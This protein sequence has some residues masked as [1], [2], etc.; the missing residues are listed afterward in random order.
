MSD[1]ERSPDIDAY[2]SR[3]R[4]R[5]NVVIA[6]ILL[7][8]AAPFVLLFSARAFELRATPSEAAATFTLQRSCGAVL[9]FGNRALLLSEQGCLDA[10]AQGYATE[11]VRLA[12]GSGQQQIEV[13][14]RPLP[15]KVVIA[16]DSAAEFEV[17]V[18]RN[19]LGGAS[20]IEV[21]LERG[22]HELLVRG[23]RIVPIERTIDVTG[24][25]EEQRFDFATE[26]SNSKFSVRALPDG[27]EILLD[28]VKVGQAAHAD[29]VALGAHEVE[30]RLDGYHSVVRRFTAEPNS[31]ADLGLIEL[32]PKDAI[33]SLSSAPTGASVLVDD[34]FVGVAPLR[35]RLAALRTHGLT[36]RKAGHNAIETRIRP[37]PG[38]AIQR[39]FHLGGHRFEADVSADVEAHLTVNGINRGKTPMSVQVREGDRI[40]VAREGY[41]TQSVTVARVGG[42]R[43][44][45]AFRMMRPN[46]WAFDQAPAVVEAA[47]GST[48]R[49]FPPVRFR[50]WLADES[51]QGGEKTLKRA[52]YVGQ[53]EVDYDGFRSFD[54]IAIPKGLSGKHP[55]ANITWKRAAEFCNWLSRREGLDPVYEFG[56]RGELRRVESSA[57]GYRLPTEA[58]WEAVSGYDFNRNEPVGPYPWGSAVTIPRAYANFA[59]REA[60][61][62]AGRLLVGHADNH[63]STAPTGSYPANFNGL[64]D[65]AG[66]VA[67]WTTDYYAAAPP[68]ADGQS[69]V[70][71]LGPAR[72]V[73][74]VVK[75]SSFKSHA[76]SDLVS[77]HRM[78]ESTK[79]DSVGFRIARWIH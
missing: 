16:V 22:P 76:L 55:V 2:I 63:A 71:P 59:G 60:Q 77:G 70:D 48:L 25:G 52:F 34:K 39:T 33:L 49:K 37:S 30:V 28:G 45:Y 40:S 68:G 57:L 44:T 8:A 74:H 65:L 7:L 24:Y 66:N 61:A 12:K 75:G 20:P 56:A 1:F 32:E 58:E 13:V 67:E 69:L 64:Y 15:G 62:L 72:G 35:I 50:P 23:P 42:P 38:E 3:Q 4:R 26:P 11:T 21:E 79:S 29:E 5:R 43:R 53:R 51:G 6:A 54:P 18:D 73:D 19:V 31:L 36:I 78:F 14:L 46:E 47:D 10:T 17:L 9:V 41:Q 27:A